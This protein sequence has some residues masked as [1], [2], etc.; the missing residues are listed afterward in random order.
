MS[1]STADSLV[2][3]LPPRSGCFL[4]YADYLVACS[5][6]LAAIL[7]GRNCHD[8]L[9]NESIADVLSVL[10]SFVW[11]LRISEVQ[12]INSADMT[13]FG[14]FVVHGK[15]ASATRVV[16]I[17]FSRS[18]LRRIYSTPIRTYVCG[19]DYAKQHRIASKY[20]TPYF[21]ADFVGAKVTHL[22]RRLFIAD[23]YRNSTIGETAEA[24]GHRDSKNT[25]HYLNRRE[26]S[27]G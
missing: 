21:P 27:H 10:V 11:G 7:P 9:Y 24:I 22:G 16:S 2:T 23:V 17:P 18:T 5:D 20:V 1:A 3:S 12:A 26:P 14:L 4:K 13:R 8:M 6:M 25:N 19:R 15:K